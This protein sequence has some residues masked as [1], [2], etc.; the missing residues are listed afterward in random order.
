MVLVFFLGSWFLFLCVC[1]C[2]HVCLSVVYVCACYTS[3]NFLKSKALSGS[4][5]CMHVCIILFI[6]KQLVSEVKM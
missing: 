6:R 2:V 5:V 4:Q 1:V 3:N